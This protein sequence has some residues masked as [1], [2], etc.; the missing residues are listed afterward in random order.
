MYNESKHYQIFMLTIYLFYVKNVELFLNSLLYADIEFVMF[1]TKKVLM[2]PI[3]LKHC[4][5]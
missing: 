5:N 3:P 1:C 2:K 4:S